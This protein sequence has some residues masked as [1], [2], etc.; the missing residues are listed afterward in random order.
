MRLPTDVGFVESVTVSTVAVA[1][2]TVPTAPLL[3]VT[4]L[5]AAVVSKPK[6]LIVMV[7]ALATTFALLV[8]TTGCTVAICT[9]EPL[10]TLLT[11]TIAV[12]FPTDVGLVVRVTVSDVAVAAATVP[13]APLL[14]TTVFKLAV[15]LKPAPAMTIV[16]ALIGKP[17]VLLVTTGMTVATWTAVPL[18]MVFVVTIAV[19]LPSTFGRVESVTVRLVSVAVVTVPTAPLLSTTVFRF[20]T[21]SKP[22]PLMVKVVAVILSPVV[23]PVTTGTTFATLIAAPLDRLFVV[24][25]AV[26]LPLAIGFVLSVTVKEVAVAAVTVPTAPLLR[27]TEF[28]FAIG[29][30]PRPLIVRVVA[31][32]ARFDV[33]LVTT[34]TTV[35]T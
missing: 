19:I 1:V 24:T 17:A 4:V 34:G 20:A 32:A 9:A 31:V 33:L 2:V 22:K 18:A 6:P 3:S 15:A 5:L 21:G 14:N 10:A 25:T 29:S 35:A 28:R 26:R 23:L 7:A 30:N 11:V 13:T 12:R 8:V 16:A 27:T